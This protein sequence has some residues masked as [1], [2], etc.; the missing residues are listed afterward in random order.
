PAWR[1]Q[2]AWLLVTLAYLFAFPYY[3]QLNNPNE[4]AR[5]WATRAIVEHGVLNIDELQR[6]WGYVND[7]AKNERHVYSG[8]AP[9]ASFLGVPVLAGPTKLRHLMGLP[10]PGKRETTFW[11]RLVALK[12]PL[13]VFLWFF[14]RYVERLTGSPAARDLLVVGLGLGTLMYPYGQIFTGHALAAA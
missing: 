5:I 10:S 8:K 3:P 4:N 2:A 7:K 11:L 12:L 14:A 6:E 1:R 13:V 9:G